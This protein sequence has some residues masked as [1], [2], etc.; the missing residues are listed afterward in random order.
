MFA[1]FVNWGYVL[2]LNADAVTGRLEQ[3]EAFT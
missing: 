2:R 3:K 1:G